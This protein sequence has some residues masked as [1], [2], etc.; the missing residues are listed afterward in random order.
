MSANPL[1]TTGGLIR[2]ARLLAGRSQ[3][4]LADRI[5]RDRAHIARWERDGAE[6]GL[7]TLREVLQAC[8]YEL[9]IA[10]IKFDPTPLELLK[11]LRGLT[12][13]QRVDRLVERLG[14]E[15]PE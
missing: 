2:Q 5:G 11:P 4:E 3:V 9:S 6:P 10:L 14:Q 7:T 12:P 15:V 13:A 1:L 8:G